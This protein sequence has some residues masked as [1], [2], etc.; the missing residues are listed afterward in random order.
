MNMIKDW[1]PGHRV[2]G[3]YPFLHNEAKALWPQRP[4][5]K[6]DNDSRQAFFDANEIEYKP[7]LRAKDIAILFSRWVNEYGDT[8][9]DISLPIEAK[10]D[11]FRKEISEGDFEDF[12]MFRAAE[13]AEALET[14]EGQVDDMLK[15]DPFSPELLGFEVAAQN[16][17]V[18]EA[19]M[20]MYLSTLDDRFAIHRAPGDVMSNDWN[21]HEWILIKKLADGS[22]QSIDL[23]IPCMRIG[24]AALAAMGVKM[25]PEKVKI[26]EGFRKMDDYN[27]YADKDDFTYNF[28]NGEMIP[29][30]T[31]KADENPPAFKMDAPDAGCIRVWFNRTEGEIKAW[32]DVSA[33]DNQEALS[34]AKFLLETNSE[35]PIADIQ[36]SEL[37]VVR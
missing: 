2:G 15:E 29:I 3:G 6:V 24:Y 20:R 19:P 31:F 37:S 26:P 5:I 14:A 7:S 28:V 32:L 10:Y 8:H 4:I 34:K 21:P 11:I 23:T 1:N 35:N 12:M 30:P 27:T 17:D 16:K 25:R 18:T 22:L 36:F 9:E 13:F 33:T